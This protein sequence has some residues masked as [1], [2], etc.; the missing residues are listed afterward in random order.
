MT[1]PRIAQNL[2]LVRQRIADACDKFGR[3]PSEVQLL[4]VSKTKPVEMVRAAMDAG[5]SDFGE[6]YLQ[7]A[8]E[9]I[10]SI[11]SKDVIWHYIGAIQ[12]NK[13]RTIA[14]HFSWIH[15]VASLKVARRLNDQTTARPNILI[16]VNV[17]GEDSKAGITPA[18]L[19]SLVES[20]IPLKNIALRGLMT[21]PAHSEDF[22]E[23]R[24]PFRYLRELLE[25]T[26]ARFGDDLQAFDQ[27]SM[28]MTADLEAAIAEGATW[29]RIGSAIFGQRTK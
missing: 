11:H 21:I 29:L 4:A 15:T 27:L 6:N 26:N 24:V 16:Q 28:G 20:I 7:E 8:V 22:D 19:P 2:D 12:S 18:E 10:E 17:S 14:E 5:H 3:N 9:K 23:Q 13:T 1:S 25:D